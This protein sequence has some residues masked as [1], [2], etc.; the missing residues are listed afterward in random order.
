M[1]ALKVNGRTVKTHSTRLACAVEA[2]E[3]GLGWRIG[4][5]APADIRGRV[6]L[7]RTAEIVRISKPSGD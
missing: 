4:M 1:Y 6:V 7:D 2:I 3:R 5:D